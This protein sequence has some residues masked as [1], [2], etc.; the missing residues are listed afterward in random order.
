MRQAPPRRD[1]LRTLALYIVDPVE[2]VRDGTLPLAA[3]YGV[4]SVDL[5]ITGLALQGYLRDGVSF[6]IGESLRPPF[7]PVVGTR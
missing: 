3:R 2:C 5:L 6:V 7:R 4:R 1:S